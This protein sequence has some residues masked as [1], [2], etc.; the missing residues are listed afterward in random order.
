NFSFCGQT[1]QFRGTSQN[2]PV[3]KTCNGTGSNKQLNPHPSKPYV[4]DEDGSV[5]CF[6]CNGKGYC[7]TCQ[8][9]GQTP[10]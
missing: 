8:G 6:T 4:D 2:T 9:T 3:C 10:D 1:R 7:L 5:T